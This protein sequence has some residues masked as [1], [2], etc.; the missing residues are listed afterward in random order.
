M[1]SKII[2]KSNQKQRESKPGYS[3]N[4]FRYFDATKF[5]VVPKSMHKDKIIQGCGG[6]SA[7]TAN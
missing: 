7:K 1:I 4:R 2:F 3:N 5:A 6:K